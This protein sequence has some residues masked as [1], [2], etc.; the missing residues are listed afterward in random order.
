MFSLPWHSKRQVWGWLV[1][2]FSCQ[3]LS[4]VI[5]KAVTKVARALATTYS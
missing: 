5:A 3:R 4:W 2:A 1:F